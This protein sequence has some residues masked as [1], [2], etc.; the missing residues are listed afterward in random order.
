MSEYTQADL[1]AINKAIKNGVTEVKYIGP[2]GEKTVKY[3]SLDEMLRV[4]QIIRED[5]GLVGNGGRKL[6]SFSKGIK[7]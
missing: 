1:D 7:S 3:R 4:R 6:T 2:G 5:L